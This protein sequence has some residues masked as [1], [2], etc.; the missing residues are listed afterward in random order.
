MS[1]EMY[2]PRGCSEKYAELCALSTT[3]EL[4]AEEFAELDAHLNTC[5]PCADLLTEYTSF[6]QAGMAKLAIAFEPTIGPSDPQRLKKAEQRLKATIQATEDVV[7]TAEIRSTSVSPAIR[8]AAGWRIPLALGT[9]AAVLLAIAG[10]FQLG[11]KTEQRLNQAEPIAAASS[12]MSALDALRTQMQSRL[13]QAQDELKRSDAATASANARV[14]ELTT[15]QR[16][17]QTHMDDLARNFNTASQELTSTTEQRDSLQRQLAD[18]AKSLEEVKENLSHALQDRQ[19]AM[20]RVASLETEVGRLNT[21]MS[22]TNKSASDN[23]TYLA[24]DRD[25]RELM[26]ARQLHIADVVDVQGNGKRSKPFGRVFYT[27]GRSLIFYAFDLQAEP[28]YREAKA[29]QAWAQSDTAAE[30]PV[31]LGIFY[32][33]SEKNRRWVLKSDNP[34]V[35][36][37][38]NRVFVTVEPHG[39]SARPTGKPFLEASLHSLPPNHP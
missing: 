19:G 6:V 34:D 11:R 15:L 38:I 2:E 24:E 16:T 32:M 27:E 18:E 23:Q 4:S 8:R 22:M 10:A 29:F 14:E 7:R 3:G 21:A 30:K 13:N 25:I 35:L 5:Q 26:G 12:G 36:A 37:Q 39:G 17:M 31:S 9:A 33:D 20:L 1:N 28:G